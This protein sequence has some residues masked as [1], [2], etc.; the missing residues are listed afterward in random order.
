MGLSPEDEEYI[1]ARVDERSIAK[2]NRDFD[3]ADYIRDEL[4]QKFDIVIQDKLKQWSVGGDFGP[5]GPKPR[6]VYER[7]G[8]GD[9]TDEQLENIKKLLFERSGA[10]KNR[11]FDTADYIR[12]NLRDEYN[13]QID[14]KSMEWHVDSPD[15]IQV[16]EPGAAQVPQYDVDFI[17]AKIVE[18]HAYKT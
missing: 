9:L 1:T 8:G 14:D 13:I 17:E 15:F 5:D 4:N 6:G 18:R 10:K 7:R 2:K 11:D 16:F 12:D 3:T